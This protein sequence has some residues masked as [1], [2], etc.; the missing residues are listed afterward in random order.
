MQRGEEKKKDSK[1]GRKGKKGV[2]AVQMKERKVV[3]VIMLFLNVFD[4]T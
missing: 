1:G 3:G 4:F 2:H